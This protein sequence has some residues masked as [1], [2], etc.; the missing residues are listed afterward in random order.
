MRWCSCILVAIVA[1]AT[2][3]PAATPI[4]ISADVP[5]TTP[6]GTLQPWQIFRY[7]LPGPTYTLI[8]S[9]PGN[10][11]LDGI[12]KMDAP[13]D[14]LFSVES[15]SN[16]G[17]SLPADAQ[18]GD[19]IR[20]DSSAASYSLVFC[21][22]LLGIPA[23][24]NV[25]AVSLEGGDAGNLILSF[26][27]PTTLGATTFEPADLV[28]FSPTGA[29]GCGAW[30]LSALNPAFDASTAGTGVA[31]SS[32]GS[33][34]ATA[35][36]VTLLTYDVPTDLGPPAGTYVPGQVVSWNGAAFAV[37]E[38]LGGW[39]RGSTIDGL[40]CE[41]NP[42]VVPT[43]LTMNK[44]LAPPSDVVLSWSASCAGGAQDYGIYEGTIGTWYGHTQIDC[45]DAGGDL[46]EQVTPGAGNRYY[47]VV[48]H[49]TKEEGSYGN[50]S[51]G[52]DRPVGAVVCATP[53]VITPC[54]P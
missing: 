12:Q 7:D 4:Y 15:A 18:P 30:V 26:D 6:V 36:G 37:Y 54:P 32:N 24:A 8:L 35:D 45:S 48:P 46:T 31:L 29:A 17:G 27:V 43:T 40:S 16:L 13:G 19:V 11:Q 34:A 51:S 38:T 2:L 10:P 23:G 14:W 52:V 50:A 39:P 33:D 28:R 22:N 53:Q 20:F 47:L 44:A 25:D 1:V 42:G 5:T 3:L 21:G 9:V 41:A 49:N